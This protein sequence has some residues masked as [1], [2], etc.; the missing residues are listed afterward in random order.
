VSDLKITLFMLSGDSMQMAILYGIEDRMRA[1]LPG[2]KVLVKNADGPNEH[3]IKRWASEL[4]VEESDLVVT[5]GN[6]SSQIALEEFNGRKHPLP[7]IFC[8]IGV[9]GVEGLEQERERGLDFATA[10]YAEPMPDHIPMQ[11]VL[12][13]YPNVNTVFLPYLRVAKFERMEY[14]VQRM[15][16]YCKDRE[17]E[18][19]S[20]AIDEIKDYNEL[21]PFIRQADV[22]LTIEGG[23]T[24]KDTQAIDA[25]CKAEGKPFVGDGQQALDSGGVYG[26]KDDYHFMG[27]KVAEYAEQILKQ[28]K[29][30]KELEPYMVAFSR[31]LRTA[32]P[33]TG[34]FISDD[35]LASCDGMFLDKDIPTK[36][37]AIA[38]PGESV[39]ALGST[40]LLSQVLRLEKRVQ[41]IARP[42]AAYDRDQTKYQRKR[43]LTGVYEHITFFDDAHAYDVWQEAKRQKVAMP[44][45]TV[46]TVG[47]NCVKPKWHHEVRNAGGVLVHV[48]LPAPDP[49]QPLRMLLEAAPH[50][51]HITAFVS[52]APDNL[53]SF[54]HAR[55]AQ[56]RRACTVRGVTL[57]VSG[58]DRS[59]LLPQIRREH[60][61]PEQTDACFFYQDA[62]N[63]RQASH[64]IDICRERGIIVC[65]GGVVYGQISPLCYGVNMVK[66]REYLFTYLDIYLRRKRL[67]DNQEVIFSHDDIYTTCVN[68][69]ICTKMGLVAPKMVSCGS[70]DTLHEKVIGPVM[71]ASEREDGSFERLAK[72]EK[73]QSARAQKLFDEAYRKL[74]G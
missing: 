71:N 54:L 69:K 44:P 56:V 55:L 20:Q 59:D 28:G 38:S 43:L 73:E 2:A 5:I 37:I 11:M 62:L 61:T 68:Q 33:S 72:A 51:K 25:C 57:R 64:L 45:C 13:L 41:Y 58:S 49:L 66:L 47:D 34:V 29:S 24:A 23:L 16:E 46:V 32:E 4:T 74:N 52:A 17:I 12:R 65:A 1:I 36:T 40:F 14:E 3:L 63:G 50:I 27:A 31:G 70:V 19:I 22:T 35:V 42:Y 6:R 15:V 10:V 8:A 48:A 7:A 39:L 18:V 26:F 53:P 9:E 67:P 30:P 21:L 60:M